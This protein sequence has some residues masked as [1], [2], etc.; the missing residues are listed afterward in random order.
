MTEARRSLAFF[1]RYYFPHYIVTQN[2]KLHWYLYN[3]LKRIVEAET[4]QRV[5]IA[6]PRGNAKSSITSLI[7]II[8][9]IVYQKKHFIV[10]LSDTSSQAEEFLSS[11]RN[12]LETNERLRQDFGNLVGDSWKSDDII[13]KNQVRVLALGARKKI[14]G[15]RF[16][17]KRPDLIIGDDME[18]DENT[19]NPEQRK[20][21]ENWFFKAVSKAGDKDTDIIVIGTIIHYDSLL[22]ALLKNP[23]YQGKVFRAVE[24]FSDSDLW[25]HW[26]DVY[27]RM[28]DDDKK[29]PVN[30][31]RQYYLDH[32]AELMQGVTVLWPEGQSYYSLME[33]R[34]TEGP[35]SFDSE[36]QNNPINPND[37]LFQDDWFRYIEEPQWDKYKALYGACDPSMGKTALSDFSS[38][39]ILAQHEDGYLD[40]IHSSIE[41]RHPDQILADIFSS[42]KAIIEAHPDLTFT[43]YA[44]ESVQFQ[45]YF[46]DK[47]MEE[48]RKRG[49]YLP[50]VA[51]D[52]QTS[53]KELRI[54][55]LQ[56]LVKNGV[57]RFMKHHRLLLEQLRY[58]PLADHDDGPDS[59]EMA[60]RKARRPKL[61]SHKY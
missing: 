45:E 3:E 31:A 21:N 42:A 56:P 27:L 15:R 7:F 9:C 26:E 41:R 17:N 52:N 25:T 59:L 39:T 24:Q 20:K 22:S 10:L 4:G 16:N 23:V 44:I 30:P 34:L 37:C 6:A 35:A 51:T 2:S 57:I 32:E 5:A 53:K 1:A 46:R 11:I 28:T 12:E 19:V 29:R 49:F 8:W 38:I 61:G 36:Y 13:T 33:M 47:V 58:Y 48:S 50:V 54:Q 43:A 40:V 14:R 60:V 18:N 55:S